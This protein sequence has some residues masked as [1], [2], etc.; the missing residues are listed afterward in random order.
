MTCPD[1]AP[2]ADVESTPPAVWAL[3]QEQV[4]A[5]WDRAEAAQQNESSTR[6]EN[7]LQQQRD[8]TAYL[9]EMLAGH[10][11]DAAALGLHLLLVAVEA[12]QAAHPGLKRVRRPAILRRHA[13]TLAILDSLAA[14]PE[15]G[16]PPD[17]AEPILMELML[18][19]IGEATPEHQPDQPDELRLQLLHALWTV[20]EVLHEAVTAAPGHALP[21]MKRRRR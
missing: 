11:E 15:A 1:A 13:A 8:L 10:D 19:V 16:G 20:S 6:V 4:E 14:S 7:L 18:G 5:A 9:L 17:F 21:V 2:P 12:F 3:S